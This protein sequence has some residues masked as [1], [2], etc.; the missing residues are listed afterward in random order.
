M[1]LTAMKVECIHSVQERFRGPRVKV[2]GVP[3]PPTSKSDQI[4]NILTDSGQIF[5]MWLI[6]KICYTTCYD[7]LAFSIPTTCYWKHPHRIWRHFENFWVR[8]PGN[9]MV[10]F[11]PPLEKHRKRPKNLFFLICTKI[12][13]NVHPVGDYLNPWSLERKRNRKASVRGLQ[14]GLFCAK[15]TEN[16]SEQLLRECSQ[17]RQ[18]RSKVHHNFPGPRE[19]FRAY[20]L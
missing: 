20:P 8:Q 4:F 7:R 10:T 1:P 2:Y 19:P 11:Q 16:Q 13:R 14:S 18:W 6:G 3:V 17:R 12:C 9:A 5:T 15:N